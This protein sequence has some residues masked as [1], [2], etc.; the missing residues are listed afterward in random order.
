M[1]KNEIKKYWNNLS[2]KKKIILPV[3]IVV[4][5][6]QIGAALYVSSL[7]SESETSALVNKAKA[8][9]V[10]IE[11]VR[12]FTSK[13]QKN[14]VFKKEID[15]LDQFL[16]TVP[17]V[18]AMTVAKEKAKELGMKFR[19]P[20]F[21]PRNE[22]NTPDEFE[23]KVLKKLMSEGIDEYW[24]NDEKTN[25]LRYFR[26]VRLTKECLMCHGDPKDS[27]KYWGRSDGTD[28]TGA[29]ME[30]WKEGEIHGA[31]EILM[32]LEEVQSKAFAQMLTILVIAGFTSFLI[33]FIAWKST[34]EVTKPLISF[35][36][37]ACKIA[38]GDFDVELKTDSQDE[39]GV[40]SKSLKTMANNLKTNQD[41]LLSQSQ[42]IEE[43]AKKA[44]SQKKYLSTK[45]D[46]ILFEMK[47]FASGD[48]RTELEISSEDE[49]GKLFQGFNKAVSNIREIISEIINATVTISSSTSEIS[50]S[51]EEISAGAREQTSQTIDISSA[52]EE[53][54]QNIVET[55][56]NT[57]AASESA[58]R[59]GELAENG[60][61]V[62]L[63]S[64]E[65]M[66]NIA[67]VVSSATQKV[68]ELGVNSERI[69]HI[70]NVIDE[71]ADQTNL[72]ALN[73]A[74]EAA[75]AG[76]HGKSFAVVADEVR[77]LA[78]R[79]SKATKE[80]EQTIT[81][82]QQQT[83]KAV[84][85]MQKGR[86]ETISGK[87]LAQQAGVKLVEILKATDQVSNVVTQVSAASEEQSAT[88]E[89]ISLNVDGI[90]KVTE[91]TAGA[92]S[93]IARAT[94]DLSHLNENLQ[95]MVSQFRTSDNTESQYHVHENGRLLNDSDPA[96]G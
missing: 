20:K 8:M 10:Q 80:I 2:V 38:K 81:Q 13:Q 16:L 61:N 70:I 68:A 72:L 33:G 34:H 84:I 49:I 64:I 86:D 92:I 37:A 9:L 45:I 1:R 30:G 78:E 95:N 55:A 62:V 40:L 58:K 52:V 82:I 19:V 14:K 93:Q 39:L 31:F 66:N 89:E 65:G 79:T 4:V 11:G 74:I 87:E 35:K 22:K 51:L 50:S 32:P 88:A 25:Q 27:Y 60:G 36:D 91:E 73:A 17:I 43:A 21:S 3:L 7:V 71:I 44:E 75:R 24:A 94:D 54:N 26:A 5:F 53:M 63:N 23:A 69:G 67:T 59:A 46:E 15:D 77:K 12:E 48:L 29:K 6:S 57:L 18:S 83:E 47:K 96:L 28:I 76:E 56:K 41:N 42:K 85:S 90:N